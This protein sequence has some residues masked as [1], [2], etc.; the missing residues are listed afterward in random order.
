MITKPAS[1]KKIE[2]FSWGDEVDRVKIY[3]ETS[4]F[5]DAISAEMV[6]LRAERNACVLDVT[7]K[8]GK[9]HSLNF[10]NLLLPVIP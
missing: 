3:V 6:S 4:Q 8:S 2:K 1:L 7:D 9:V 5:A 10:K